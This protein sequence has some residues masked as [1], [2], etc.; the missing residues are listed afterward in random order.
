METNSA[1]NKITSEFPVSWVKSRSAM[2]V[3]VGKVSEMGRELEEEKNQNI[4][5][6][7]EVERLRRAIM[8]VFQFRREKHNVPHLKCRPTTRNSSAENVALVIWRC[9]GKELKHTASFTNVFSS[10]FPFFFGPDCI[11]H[12]VLAGR[13]TDNRSEEHRQRLDLL[14]V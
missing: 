8:S 6:R 10:L 13:H 11:H 14:G 9:P 2:L 7:S 5:A 4:K 3:W 12:T 1:D